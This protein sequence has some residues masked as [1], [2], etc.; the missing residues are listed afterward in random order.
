MTFFVLLATT[1]GLYLLTSFLFR[2]FEAR[3]QTLAKEYVVRGQTAL[4]QSLPTDAVAALRIANSYALDE[5][6][7]H[8][9]LAEALAASGQTDEAANYFLSLRET[10][11]G[12][13]LINLQLARLARNKSNRQQA[14]H[15]YRSAVLGTWQNAEQRQ[16]VDLEFAGYL[17]ESK[18]LASARAELLVAAANSRETVASDL[19]FGD[20]LLAAQDT[21]D[22]MTYYRK[23]LTLDPDNFNAQ[24]QIGR[25]LYDLGDYK[26]AAKYLHFAAKIAQKNAHL[27]PRYPELNALAEKAD[28]L[29]DLSLSRDLP[30]RERAHHILTAAK[31]AKARLAA[32]MASSDQNKQSAALQ[33]LDKAW[34]DAGKAQLRGKAIDE[35]ANQDFAMQLIF[36]TE[37]QTAGPCGAPQG[38]DA[39]LLLLAQRANHSAPAQ[40][41]R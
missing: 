6:N 17:I 38:D 14:I 24:Q 5:R 22:A 21:A 27:S 23:A 39:L 9:L 25:V 33:S 41:V 29:A 3:R 4:R 16:Q 31:I 13:G 30:G 2:S 28:R 10:E 19:L 8:L 40:E 11:P 32:C 18:E 15:Y 35:G 12:N 20:H 34:T 7:I 37:I 1:I 36:D 26:N